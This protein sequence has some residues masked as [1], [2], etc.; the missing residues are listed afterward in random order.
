MIALSIRRSDQ[1]WTF[2]EHMDSTSTSPN[3]YCKAEE[4]YAMC[5]ACTAYFRY[6][7]CIISCNVY[8]YIIPYMGSSVC[9][10]GEKLL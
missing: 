8:M 5:C 2:H 1:D 3:M 10:R 9:V 7:E 6:I 4:S